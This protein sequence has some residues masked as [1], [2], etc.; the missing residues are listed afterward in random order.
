M[1]LSVSALFLALSLTAPASPPAAAAPQQPR[2]EARGLFS[3]S[4]ARRGATMQGAVVLE[5]P[6]GLH[7]NSDRPKGEFLIPTVVK[8]T[9]PRGVRV[10]PVRYPRANVRRFDFSPDEPMSV[11]EGFPAVLFDLTVPASFKG[12][13]LELTAEISYQ[14]CSDVMCYPPATR[15]I[16]FSVG[17]AGAREKVEPANP[18]VFGGK[19]KKG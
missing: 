3:A 14:M 5:I 16:K 2:I 15:E 1:R 9:A 8:V 10:G 4:K 11:F 18:Q 7:I 13:E 17:V 12:G 19:K 6:T